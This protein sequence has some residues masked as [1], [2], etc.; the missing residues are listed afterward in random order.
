MTAGGSV[1]QGAKGV[2]HSNVY[3]PDID[4]LRALAVV[5]VVLFHAGL[6]PFSGGY[7]G[8]DIFFVI[9]GFL[10]TGILL[11]EMSDGR[12]SILEF[13]RRR[14]RRIFPALLAMTLATLV[15]GYM[16]LTPKEFVEL[17]ESAAAIAVFGSN[18]YFWKAVSYFDAGSQFEPLLHTWSLAVEEQYY[19]FFPLILALVHRRRSWLVAM[20]WVTT[21]ASLLLSIAMV[22]L[23][24]GAAF[25]L[26]PARA[27]ELMIGGLLAAGCIPRPRSTFAASSGASA[28]FVLILVPIFLYTDSTPFPGLAA[29]PPVL[30]ATLLIW[31]EG[32]GVAK[33]LSHPALVW[34]GLASYSL[35]LWHMPI[36]EFAKYLSN[37]PLS[38]AAGTAAS[39]L[40]LVVAWMS[41]R[42]IEA[43]FRGA[44]SPVLNGRMALASF[45]G[46]IF[47][48]F[49]ALGVIISKGAPWRFSPLAK[50]QLAIAEDGDRHPR[51]C[52][53]VDDVWIEPARACRLGDPKAASTVLLWG[54]SHAMVT[55]TA[56][57]DSARRNHQAFLFA[58]DADC[59]VGL[60]FSIDGSVS[61]GLTG[62]GHYRNC[63]RYNREMFD[64]ATT[65]PGLHT[66]V[67]SSRWTNWRIGEAANPAESDVDVRL[68]DEAGLAGSVNENRAKF[69]RG[70]TLL[71]EKLVAAG[72]KVLIVGPL[73]EPTLN[74]PHAL[75]VAEFGFADHPAAV[76]FA[77]YQGRHAVI[78]EIFRSLEKRP[79]VS[80]IW[81]ANKLCAQGRC[82]IVDEGLPLY[83]DHN[84]LS[85]AAAKRTSSLY[86]H[87][88][89]SP[90]PQR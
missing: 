90:P 32:R 33:L 1:S 88:F 45:A 18:F 60:G 25:Y 78:F 26:L 39:L 23:T 86:D 41:L 56:M 55:A 3:R 51:R 77:D 21:L 67:L 36:M 40:S 58:A 54:D 16:V 22:A 37:G 30:G 72:K 14:A 81:P 50:S 57:E 17:G 4:G 46:M 70:F 9:S 89:A 83:F 38:P 11:R 7:V 80:F 49:V 27:W 68:R 85:V 34:I 13:Y 61:P 76:T 52:M 24:P 47:L 74:V 65:S 79:G 42:W 19:I 6:A 64:L 12:Y 44:R 2:T 62:M 87:L 63:E 71:V 84:H 15:A 31:A 35:Y 28:G 20:L 73:P 66:I 29:L 8:V 82:P 53:S 43:P 10:I 59:P 75:H 69:E 48:G 5:P